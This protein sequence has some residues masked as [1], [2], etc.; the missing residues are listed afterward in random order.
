MA[1][2][3]AHVKTKLS[4]LLSIE[5]NTKA[6]FE[7]TLN[8][9]YFKIQKPDLL[10]GHVKT[11][12][13]KLDGEEKKPTDT[14][15]VQVQAITVL[16]KLKTEY[17][18]FFDILSQKEATSCDAKADI[19]IDGSVWLKD[20]PV[21]TL[22][23]MEKQLN[24]QI[25]PLL[26]KLPILS[27]DEAWTW[28]ASQALFSAP[29]RETFSKRLI[30]KALE[31]AKATDKH[32]AQV[33]LIEE[34]IVTGTFQNTNYSGALPKTD[35]DRWMAKAQSLLEATKFAR[36]EAATQPVRDTKIGTKMMSYIFG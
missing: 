25:I 9:F 24:A 19:L 22:V 7:V 34:E 14:K 28:N 30:K 32:A 20:V 27:S 36:Q 26:S 17:A 3:I 16:E 5:R 8:D 12:E 10:Y 15:I 13:P 11:H 29:P 33:Q 1:T 6:R 23:S 18:K 35:V 2:E 31:L 21:M 4:Q